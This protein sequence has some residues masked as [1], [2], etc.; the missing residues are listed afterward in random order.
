[1]P[2]AAARATASQS[3]PGGASRA[4]NTEHASAALPAP[5]AAGSTTGSTTGSPTGSADI[6]GSTSGT[7]S[8]SGSG[9]GHND[10]GGDGDTGLFGW[11]RSTERRVLTF[12]LV[13]LIGAAVCTCG[14]CIM[15]F[16][17]SRSSHVTSS[18]SYQRLGGVEINDDSF[19]GS[20]T[21]TVL[22]FLHYFFYCGEQMP[23]LP[24]LAPIMRCRAQ[25]AP[26]AFAV[27]EV[28]CEVAPSI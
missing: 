18:P 19:C 2:V 12:A 27:A 16:V 1:M 9:N 7:D 10:G 21:E 8:T 28:A 26:K 15:C 11:S 25:V 13:G 17:S 20:C 5:S 14:G 3:A 4:A 24:V 23:L 6:P 22:A